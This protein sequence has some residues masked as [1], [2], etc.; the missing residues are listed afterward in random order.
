MNYKVYNY[1]GYRIFT[2]PTDRFRTCYIEVNFRDDIRKVNI[3]T[4][5]FLAYLL[6]FSSKKYPTRRE[7]LI[8]SEELYNFEFERST[9]K[10]GYNHFTT[11]SLEFLNPKYVNE[12]DY[13]KR[14]VEYLLDTIQEPNIHN[15]KF[16]ETS[17]HVIKEK[18]FAQM[19]SYKENPAKCAIIEGLKLL[20]PKSVSGVRVI[21]EPEELK[22]VTSEDLIQEYHKMFENSY[23]DF[24]IIGNLPMDEIVRLIHKKFYKP[25][26]VTQEIPFVVEEKFTKPRRLEIQFSYSQSQLLVLYGLKTFSYFERYFALPI[27]HRIFSRAGFSD[28][29]T[30]YLRGENSLCYSTFT[31]FQCSNS[32]AYLLVGL[33][34]PNVEKALKYIRLALKEMETGV[35]DKEFFETQKEKALMDLKLRVDDALAVVENVYFHEIE[36]APLFK[37]YVDEIPKVTIK[38]MESIAKKMHEALLLILKESEKNE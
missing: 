5:N 18:L 31:H 19:D 15:G 6:G 30:K 20:F 8:L 26:I 17:F 9:S 14:C 29:I 21:G 1:E 3:T 4:R 7:N 22:K 37:E 32:Y 11:F 27:F 12:K 35:I 33:S 24:L 34:Y 25:S 28:K 2:I 38:D 36:G 16:D 13:T 10:V 23:C